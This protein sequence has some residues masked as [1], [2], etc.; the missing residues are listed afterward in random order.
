MLK[1]SQAMILHSQGS[2]PANGGMAGRLGMPLHLGRS[3]P[4]ASE[5]PGVDAQN[6]IVSFILGAGKQLVLKTGI[7]TTWNPKD[8]QPFKNGWMFGDFQ[9]FPMLRLGKNHPIDSQPFIA[10]PGVAGFLS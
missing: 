4:D 8:F 10:F 1:S 6:L 7:C 5:R 3:T 2:L 9:A